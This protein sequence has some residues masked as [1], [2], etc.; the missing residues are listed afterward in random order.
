MNIL[1]A[2]LTF[3]AF[4]QLLEYKSF[5]YSYL[6]ADPDTKEA[7]LIDPVIETVPRDTKIVKDLGLNLKYASNLTILVIQIYSYIFNPRYSFGY[8]VYK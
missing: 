8:H 5:T 1:T 7:I 4:F 3:D 2:G 6:L